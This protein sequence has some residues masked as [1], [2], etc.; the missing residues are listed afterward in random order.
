MALGTEVFAAR[1][2][3]LIGAHDPSTPL[4]LYTPFQAVH[5]PIEVPA[6]WVAPYT[7]LDPN[8]QQFA[9][10][11]AALDAAMGRIQAALTA[12]GMWRDTLLIFTTD[13]GGPVGSLHGHPHGIGGATGSQNWPLRGGKGAYFEGGVRGAA[14]IHGDRFIPPRL[15]GTDAAGLMHV[16]DI[17]PTVLALLSSE[18]I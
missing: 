5:A 10:M 2:E 11:L 18:L 9:G 8:R 16:T 1:A 7:H 6:K 13:N 12:R 14:F 15:R 17:L 4:F 3:Q